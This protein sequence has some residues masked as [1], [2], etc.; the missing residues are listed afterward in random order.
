[1]PHASPEPARLNERQ[2]KIL[3]IVTRQGYATI[4][5][6]AGRFDTS[7]QTIRRDII[8]MDRAGLLKR[9]HGGAGIV[10]GRER[11]HYDDKRHLAIEAKRAI[12]AEAARRIGDRMTV[13]IDVGTTAE[14]LAQCLLPLRVQCRVVTPNLNVGLALAGHPTIETV[15]VGG[16]ARTRDGALVGP[17]AIAL[18]EQFSF[19]YAFIGFSGFDADGAPMDFDLDKVLV[20]RAAMA[21]AATTVGI[22]DASKY[23][24]QA[25]IRLAEAGDL[26]QLLSDLRP[27]AALARVLGDAGVEIVLARETRP[28]ALSPPPPATLGG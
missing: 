3:R 5:A 25:S 16:T 17:L 27:P 13:F 14:A 21:R 10:D 22:V 9:F 6:L 1:M 2:A 24:R 19:D 23:R 18:I 11:P 8:L 20:K 28:A 12:A 4:D 15:V 7:H 26:E